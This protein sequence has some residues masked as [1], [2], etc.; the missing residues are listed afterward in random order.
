[1]TGSLWLPETPSSTYCFVVGNTQTV[2]KDLSYLCQPKEAF[3]IY[4]LFLIYKETWDYFKE[5]GKK[6]SLAK[7]L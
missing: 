3:D 2:W 5:K 6:I 4:Y 1:M 7:V